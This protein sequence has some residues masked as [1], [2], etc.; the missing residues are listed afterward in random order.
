LAARLSASFANMN[1]GQFGLHD[2]VSVTTDG[3]GVAT[4]A[5]FSLAQQAPGHPSSPA[6]SPSATPWTQWTPW[7]PGDP[8]DG[9]GYGYGD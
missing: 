4:A 5:T 1:C 8:G 3:N 6:P 9:Y 7:T 2:T